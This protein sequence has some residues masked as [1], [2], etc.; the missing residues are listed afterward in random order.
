M[1]YAFSVTLSSYPV[2]PKPERGD[3]VPE[4]FGQLV[5]SRAIG[6]PHDYFTGSDSR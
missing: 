3:S 6:E 2:P 5:L 4:I 1:L